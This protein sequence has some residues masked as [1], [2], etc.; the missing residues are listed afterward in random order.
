MKTKVRLVGAFLVLTSFLSSCSMADLLPAT[1]TPEP[2]ATPSATLTPV[3]TPTNT[4][5]PKPT[6]SATIVRLPTWDPFQPTSTPFVVQILVDGNTITAPP[7]PTS[8]NPGAGFISVNYTP[9][10]IYWGG[11]TPNSV[12]IT[13]EVEDPDEVATVFLF[14]RDFKEEDYT[15]WTKGQ[16]MLDRGQGIFTHTLIGSEIFGHDHYLRSWVYFQLVA[17]NLEGEEVGRTKVYEKAFDMYP[18]PCLTP[19]TG[20]PIVTPRRSPTPKP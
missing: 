15:P 17:I 18:C 6:P 16:V 13:A 14:V 20:C 2:S 10:K 5:T 7:S 9:K 3:D 12:A 8:S 1:S 11:C 19:L 4:N